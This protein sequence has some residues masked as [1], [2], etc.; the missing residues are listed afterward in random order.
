MSWW[1]DVF[2]I[3]KNVEKTFEKNADKAVNDPDDGRQ[4]QQDAQK[5]GQDTSS[6]AR[7]AAND[8]IE[9][10][11]PAWKAVKDLSDKAIEV[12]T[13][14]AAS[15]KLGWLKFVGVVTAIFTGALIFSIPQTAPTPD[16]KAALESLRRSGVQQEQIERLTVTQEQFNNMVSHIFVADEPPPIISTAPAV[17][18]AQAPEPFPPAIAAIAAE[19]ATVVLTTDSG[20]TTQVTTTVGQVWTVSPPAVKRFVAPDPPPRPVERPLGIT[21]DPNSC[22]VKHCLSGGNGNGPH[23]TFGVNSGFA[24][25]TVSY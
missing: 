5:V 16:Q 25:I 24:Q 2:G 11:D 23:K 19:P 18:A 4:A 20:E 9:S 14:V 6:T 12:E 21:E 1:K 3:H 22:F 17:A 10:R 15:A 13:K 8:A 7:D